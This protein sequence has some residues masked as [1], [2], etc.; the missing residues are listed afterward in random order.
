[1]YTNYLASM[2]FS[3]IFLII[4]R[5]PGSTLF[6]YTTLFR[7]PGS[8]AD[9]RP[10]VV[11]PE[12][13]R[14]RGAPVVR[15]PLARGLALARDLQPEADPRRVPEPAVADRLDRG[16]SQIPARVELGV[17]RLLPELL[18][19]RPNEDLDVDRL[20]AVQPLRASASR[21][22]FAIAWSIAQDI[23]AFDSTRGRKSHIVI[24]QAFTG[25]SAVIVAV[26]PPSVISAISPK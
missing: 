1:M 14:R 2:V 12:A 23:P 8:L 7:S 21:N 19:R 25:V 24:P 15:A 22:C 5:P 26:R 11:R 3:L 17:L 13:E 16:E 18:E 20:A 9:Q 4:R 6:P 10:R